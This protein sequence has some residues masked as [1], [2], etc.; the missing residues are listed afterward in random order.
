MITPLAKART[1]WE[2]N[3]TQVEALLPLTIQGVTYTGQFPACLDRWV[4]MDDL[5][6]VLAE[7]YILRP[8]RA[9]RSVVNAGGASPAPV[10]CA[11][12][13]ALLLQVRV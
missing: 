7:A 3:R 5:P 4:A 12:D 8:L 2:Q 1:W 10:A 13:E 6:P 9:L 11:A